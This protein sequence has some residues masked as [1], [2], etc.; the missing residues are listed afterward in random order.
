MNN[1]KERSLKKGPLLFF[2]FCEKKMNRKE[3]IDSFNLALSLK[4]YTYPRV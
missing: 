3:N 2:A 4:N 1:K